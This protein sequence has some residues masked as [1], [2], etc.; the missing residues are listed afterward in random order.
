MRGP[1]LR[2]ESGCQS[3][4]RHG[5]VSRDR[6][7]IFCWHHDFMMRVRHQIDHVVAIGIW[8]DLAI[9]DHGHYLASRCVVTIVMTVRPQRRQSMTTR[10]LFPLPPDDA[11]RQT[12][13][14][15]IFEAQGCSRIR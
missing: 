12:G 13:A 7:L 9:Y 5:I 15:A 6:E 1:R 2:F 4:T 10:S 3:L 11:Q 14:K 8:L